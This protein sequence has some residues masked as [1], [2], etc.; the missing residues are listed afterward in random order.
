MRETMRTTSTTAAE[1]DLTAPV[2]SAR[3]LSV[4][5]RGH[6]ILPPVRLELRRGE[7][8]ALIGRNGGG[9]TTLLR[10]LVGLLPRVSGE[11]AR[12]PGTVI[13]YVPQRNDL[14]PALPLRV[15]DLIRGGVDTGR[16]FLRPF[17]ASTRQRDVERAMDDTQTAQLAQAQLAELSEGQKQRVLLARALVANP[18]LLVLD[19]P[20]SAMDAVAEREAFALLD[21]VMHD[22]QLAVLVVSHQVQ[23]LIERATHLILVEKAARLALMGPLAEVCRQRAFIERY[24]PLHIPSPALASADAPPVAATA[25]E[26]PA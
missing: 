23:V 17:Y 10:T 26:S 19:E 4:G 1:L 24:G 11:V 12:A 18:H 8:W 15:I 20:T 14:D 13:G 9:K 6:S 21:R 25:L 22:R 2:L 5:Y 7:F 16:T 3:T